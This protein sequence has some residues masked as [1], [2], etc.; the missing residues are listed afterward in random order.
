MR[1]SDVKLRT[2]SVKRKHLLAHE[3]GTAWNT[4]KNSSIHI[5]P[6]EK[7]K[8]REIGGER[9]RKASFL[10]A[11]HKVYRPLRYL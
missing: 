9:K 3:R 8:E 10:S 6:S 11:S 1:L 7:E 2:N 4:R 5:H